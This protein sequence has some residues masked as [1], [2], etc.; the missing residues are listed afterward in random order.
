MTNSLPFV[1]GLIV[2]IIIIFFAIRP[3]LSIKK[4][5]AQKVFPEDTFM[6]KLSDNVFD[7]YFKH[8]YLMPI[9]LGGCLLYLYFT[10]GL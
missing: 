3:S 8:W 7:N 6:R 2:V 1:I 10:G 9:I 5:I 4:S